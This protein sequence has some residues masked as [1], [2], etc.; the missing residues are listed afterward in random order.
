M[1]HLF[2]PYEL[3]TELEALGFNEPCFYAWCEIGGWNMYKNEHEPIDYIL[4]TDG[5]PFGT[6]FIGKNWNKE[7][8]PNTKS[9]IQCSAPTYQQVIDWF[10]EKHNMLVFV[11]TTT[12]FSGHTP[13]VESKN[14]GHFRVGGQYTDYYAALTAAIQEAIKLIKNIN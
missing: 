3:A 14:K 10:R 6:F 5:N 12:D 7:I 2:I 9:K 4:K 8:V 1:K 13:T 11:D